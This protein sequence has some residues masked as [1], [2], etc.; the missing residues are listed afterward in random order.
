ME[1]R[2]TP[3]ASDAGSSPVGGSMIASDY[4]IVVLG[5]LDRI[6]IRSHFLRLSKDDRY[7]RFFTALSDSAVENYAMNVMDLE[8]GRAFG[9][10]DGNGR[11]VGLAHA[12]RIQATPNRVTCEVGF[13]VDEDERG[14]GLAQLLMRAVLEYC[15]ESGVNTLYMSCLRSNKRMQALAKSFGLNMTINFDEAYAELEIN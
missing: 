2:R 15:K 11:L 8:H 1:E 13:S 5:D 3:K 4:A 9:G 10:I 14:H 7:L 12:S 6:A